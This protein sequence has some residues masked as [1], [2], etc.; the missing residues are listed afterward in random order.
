MSEVG[1]EVGREVDVA[2]LY[3]GCDAAFLHR[4]VDPAAVDRAWVA[5]DGR[6]AVWCQRGTNPRG[7]ARVATA[8]GEPTLVGRLLA[9]AASSTAAP[10]RLSVEA[11]AVDVVPPAWRQG[12]TWS[13]HWMTVSRAGFADLAGR[14]DTAV[15]DL[16]RDH[17]EEVEGLLEAG[18]PRS[19]ARP[20]TPGVLGWHGVRDLP[21]GVLVATGCVV[22]QPDG[23]GLLRGVTT[24]PA[25]RGQGL[26]RLV[27]ASLTRAAL[28]LDEVAAL[29]VYVD[30]APA[31]AIYRGLGYDVVHSFVSGPLAVDRSSSTAASPSR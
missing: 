9:R 22:G 18:N 15:E 8:V 12:E 26:G 31:L 30:N 24:H 29:G 1:S 27:S 16:G 21:S 23:S 2:G 19:F 14:S 25:H 17:D 4:Q 7:P 5:G 20:D 6:T 28:Q 10:Q 13:W 11:G 3:V